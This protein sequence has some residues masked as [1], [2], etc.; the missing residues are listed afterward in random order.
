MCWAPATLPVLRL[1][2]TVVSA[3]ASRNA[4]TA[5]EAPVATARRAEEAKDSDYGTK[6]EISVLGLALEAGGRHGPRLEAP[7]T[8]SEL[9]SPMRWP[10]RSRNPPPRT[11]LAVLLGRF[12]AHTV[13][14]ALGR[15]T[16]LWS[17]SCGEP[18]AVQLRAAPPPATTTTTPGRLLTGVGCSTSL[19]F[20]H[21]A[22]WIHYAS[23][24]ATSTSSSISSS[25]SRGAVIARWH[26][27]VG[28]GRIQMPLL[29]SG[30]CPSRR[31]DDMERSTP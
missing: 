24:I 12:I 26:G 20:F 16:T 15:H 13:M 17:G 22:G 8:F 2:F 19:A 29:P 30:P 27:P 9:S 1:D 31:A 7:Q 5:Q 6:G 10:R 23:G 25:S 18:N 21:H 14:T 11:R 28:V 4:A 3:C